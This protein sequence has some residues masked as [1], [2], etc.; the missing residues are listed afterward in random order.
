MKTKFKSE[1]G[2]SAFIEIESDLLM[3]SLDGLEFEEM[4]G[5]EIRDAL[6]YDFQ[7]NAGWGVFSNKLPE[8]YKQDNED[9]IIPSP[10]YVKWL[11]E[12]AEKYFKNQSK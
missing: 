8:E 10:D 3:L 11:E 1:T 7:K 4:T 12:I 2:Q 9:V 5:I 6:K